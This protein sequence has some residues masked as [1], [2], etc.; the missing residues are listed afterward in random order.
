VLDCSVFATGIHALEDNQQSPLMLG[1][2]TILEFPH[3]LDVS[4]HFDFRSSFVGHQACIRGIVVGQA[5]LFMRLYEEP[6][7]IDGLHIDA[8]AT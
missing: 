1:V 6:C 2:E 7:F 4:L 5:G 8:F 3:P